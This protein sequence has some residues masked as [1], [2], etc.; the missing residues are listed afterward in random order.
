MS[1]AGPADAPATP[2]SKTTLD[3]A[4]GQILTPG[5]QTTE[6]GFTKFAMA[7]GAA[8]A[9]VG[10]ILAVLQTLVPGGTQVGAWIGVALVVV[11]AGK[12]LLAQL[13][14]TDARTGLKSDALDAKLEQ[15]HVQTV[16]ATK[17]LSA[18]QIAAAIGAITAP[19]KAA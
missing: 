5:A 16:L 14:Y 3:A 19:K 2:A 18:E 6:H 9:T 17:D 13:G 11:G 7:F 15:S 12:S 10:T 4:T 8:L 1:P